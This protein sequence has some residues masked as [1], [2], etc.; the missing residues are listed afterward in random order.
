MA[1]GK[2]EKKRARWPLRLLVLAPFIG[3]SWVPAY[4]WAEPGIAGVPFFYWYQ[5]FWIILGAVLLAVVY[6]AERG[7]PV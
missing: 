6:L 2:R 3:L 4:N 1:A 5:L 7:D